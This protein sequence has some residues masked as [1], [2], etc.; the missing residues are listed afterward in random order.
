MSFSE[1]L[2][3][4]DN[5]ELYYNET[6]DD[7]FGKYDR[8]LKRIQEQ[9]EDQEKLKEE[10]KEFKSGIDLYNYLKEKK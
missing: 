7:P 2:C 4:D 8:P 9:L 1:F 3:D 5:Y 10:T 6:G